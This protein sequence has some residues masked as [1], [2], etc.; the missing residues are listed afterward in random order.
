[1][2]V[3]YI[4]TTVIV[5]KKPKLSIILASLY[6]LGNEVTSVKLRIC[7]L[8]LSWYFWI[9][10]EIANFQTGYRLSLF[11]QTYVIMQYS[12]FLPSCDTYLLSEV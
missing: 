4:K 10:T 6:L 3:F 8:L 9:A 5:F 1:M 12:F 11:T 2:T 7:G